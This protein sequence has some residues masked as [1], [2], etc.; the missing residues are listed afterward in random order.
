MLRVRS[1]IL[2]SGLLHRW[3]GLRYLCYHL[4]T[5]QGC[6]G[7]EQGSGGGVGKWARPLHRGGGDVNCLTKCCPP[8]LTI[9]LH[10][11]SICPHRDQQICLRVLACCSPCLKCFSDEGYFMASFHADVGTNTASERL[12]FSELQEF[13]FATATLT[14]CITSVFYLLWHKSLSIGK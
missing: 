12:F 3:R 10:C 14:I 9:F 1:Q 4:L 5:S 11:F 7:R 13:P 8:S 2:S 6:I